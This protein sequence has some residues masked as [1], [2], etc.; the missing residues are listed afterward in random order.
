MKSASLSLCVAIG[1][2]SC[3]SNIPMSTSMD[4]DIVYAQH[5]AIHC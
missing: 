3:S 4:D 1:L 5:E 2:F